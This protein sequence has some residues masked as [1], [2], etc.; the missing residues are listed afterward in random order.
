MVTDPALCRYCLSSEE[1]GNP[2]WAPCACKGNM[3]WIHRDCLTQWMQ[4]QPRAW[5]QCEL[6]R[7]PYTHVSCTVRYANPSRPLWAIV[8]G[9]SYLLLHKLAKPL[10]IGEVIMVVLCL[11]GIVSGYTFL[12]YWFWTGCFCAVVLFLQSPVLEFMRET[13]RQGRITL[14]LTNSPLAMALPNTPKSEPPMVHEV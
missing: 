5:T 6:C 1:P 8:L 9:T 3:K 4:T 12:V 11:T 7:Q 2:L 14:A 13:F 10:V